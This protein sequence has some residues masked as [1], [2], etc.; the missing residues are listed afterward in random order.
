MG[1]ADALSRLPLPVENEIE[2][3]NLIASF[4]ENL[5]VSEEEIAKKT[6]EEEILKTVYS[7]GKN[8]WP[9]NIKDEEI[10]KFYRKRLSLIAENGCLFYSDRIV[11]LKIL[12]EKVT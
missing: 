7:Y 6:N 1:N 3:D 9:E 4:T 12:R 5:A 11:I 8:C 2:H 10:R